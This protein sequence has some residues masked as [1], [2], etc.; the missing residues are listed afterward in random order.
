MNQWI[1]CANYKC[2]G[3]TS[4]EIGTYCRVGWRLSSCY[5]E[6]CLDKFSPIFVCGLKMHVTSYI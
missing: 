5:I 3:A 4:D 1:S 2:D 6:M